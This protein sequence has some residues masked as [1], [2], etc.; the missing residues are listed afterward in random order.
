MLDAFLA[1]QEQRDGARAGIARGASPWSVRELVD[2]LRRAETLERNKGTDVF[3]ASPMSVSK[4]YE[5]R[6]RR[7]AMNL[8]KA[9]ESLDLTTYYAG[10]LIKKRSQFDDYDIAYRANLE[11]IKNS[12]EFMLFVPGDPP[13]RPA[14]TQFGVDRAGHGACPQ[15]AVHHLGTR[16]GPS[17]MGGAAGNP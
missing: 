10:R 13:P 16:S 11:H 14:R 1:E 15:R 8:V 9:L 3:I 17:A 2:A 12:R 7:L 4:D 5:G 6:E